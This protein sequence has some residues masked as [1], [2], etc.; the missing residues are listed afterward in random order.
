MYLRHAGATVIEVDHGQAVLDHLHRSGFF[1]AV[2][3][4]FQ[5]PGMDGIEVTKLVRSSETQWAS[6]PIIAVTARSDES[7]V[8]AA[9]AAGMNGFLVKPVDQSLLYEELGKVIGHRAI[10]D[11]SSTM[12]APAPENG[13]RLLN[14][15]RLE[16]YRKLGMLSELMTEYAPEL[17]RLIARVSESVERSDRDATLNALHT[18][19]GMS[20]EAGAQALYDKVRQVYVPLFEQGKWPAAGWLSDLRL[21]ADRSQEALQAYC[22]AQADTGSALGRPK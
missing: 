3:L 13:A 12:P 21:L 22:A 7:A 10:P 20:G 4:D 16:S 9:R 8:T 6:V 19:L 1:D 5:M 11:R 18:L 14:I 15:P 2:V 17:T